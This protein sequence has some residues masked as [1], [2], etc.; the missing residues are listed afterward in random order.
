MIYRLT[1][2]SAPD[3]C[4]ISS[5]DQKLFASTAES[6]HMTPNQVKACTLSLSNDIATADFAKPVQVE[7]TDM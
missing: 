2:Q 7:V 5:D 6:E 3:F 1:I 4:S